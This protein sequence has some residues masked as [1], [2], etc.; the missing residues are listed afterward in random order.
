MTPSG[1]IYCNGAVEQSDIRCNI[2]E[3]NGPPPQ[4]RPTSC[5]QTWGHVFT[6]SATGPARLECGPAP[7]RV[8]FTAIAPYGETGTFGDISC[9]SETTGLT[10]RNLSGHGFSLSRDSQRLY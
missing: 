5:G 8:D 3:R 6:M 10:C 9:R 7:S 1:N 4:P 2:V